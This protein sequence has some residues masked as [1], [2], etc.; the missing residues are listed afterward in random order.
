MATPAAVQLDRLIAIMA[1]LRAP[2]GCPWDREQTLK[3]LRPYLIEEAY[4]VLEAV[5]HEDAAAHC[6]ELG[7]LLLQVVFHAQIRAEEGKFGMAE[8][9]QAISDKLVH[10][11]PHVFG[12]VKV[13]DTEELLTRWAELKAREK[14]AKGQ[15]ASAIAG[16]PKE[17]PA[18]GRAERI[19]EKAGRVGFDWPDASGPRSKV[20]EELRELDQALSGGAPEQVEHEIG[21]L[22]FAV[23]NLSRK[24]GV[25]P[26]HALRA[27]VDRFDRRFRSIEA[28]LAREGKKPAGATLEEMDRL[29]DQAKAEEK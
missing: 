1:R 5:D 9:A 23:V 25:H 8:V 21:D 17:M 14:A 6:E 3:T 29:W 26:E 28:R 27:A 24:T 16:V 11:H 19:T 12:D 13:K 2:G 18:L 22:L 15:D 10:R 20:D 4:E 7:D